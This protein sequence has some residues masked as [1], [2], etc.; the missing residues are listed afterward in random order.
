MGQHSNVARILRNKKKKIR[1]GGNKN[2]NQELV[3]F[4]TNA[5]GLKSK[6]QSLK[7][8]LK[9]VSASIFTIQ[10]THFA[11]KGKLKIDNFS[12]FEAIRNKYN[13]GTLIGVHNSL[14]PML[15]SEYSDDFELIVVEIEAGKS[16][17]RIISGY[18]PQESW[19]ESDR[20]PFFLALDKE[21]VKATLQGKSI[22]IQM[23]SN[24]K[25][26]PEIIPN[27]HHQQ[28]QNARHL[29][30]IIM[31]N[32]LIVTNAIIDKVNGLITRRRATSES[33]E[34]SI[35][36]H[37]IISED[38]NDIFENLY[39]DEERK[40]AITKIMKTKTGVISK[41]SDHNAMISKFRFKW[42]KR[43]LQKRIEM[44]NLKNIEG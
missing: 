24:S 20:I 17:V 26:G 11:K 6:I 12:I 13:G 18:G 43:K 16:Q 8:E 32:G 27:V 21:I 25:L 9:S 7:N 4:S 41:E 22:I 1:R 31:K 15:I 19:N 14:K 34:E 23:D 36:D 39:I 5:A 3:I 44:Y 30:E 29:S 35:I 38:I 28:S 2:K 40:H 33:V 37:L 42:N 10:E